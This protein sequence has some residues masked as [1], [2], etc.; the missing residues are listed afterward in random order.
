MTRVEWR[1]LSSVDQQQYIDSVL[2]LKTKPSRIGLN[3][4]L[5]DDFTFVHFTL[6]KQSKFKSAESASHRGFQKLMNTFSSV[7]S[8]AV[9]LPWHRYFT[10]LYTGA[11]RDCG[12]KGPMTY[13]LV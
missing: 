6:N 13:V 8:S 10:F 9:F 1:Q 7:H 2:C 4:S 5:Y 3:S 11:I 12:Y